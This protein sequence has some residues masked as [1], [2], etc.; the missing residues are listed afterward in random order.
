MHTTKFIRHLAELRYGLPSPET[1]EFAKLAKGIGNADKLD[2]LIVQL[3]RL[4]D[5]VLAEHSETAE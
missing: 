2:D 4:R 5:A 1:P 3:S